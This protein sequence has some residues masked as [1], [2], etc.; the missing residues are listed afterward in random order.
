MNR[1]RTVLL[2]LA[3]IIQAA[4]LQPAKAQGTSTRRNPPHPHV[5]EAVVEGGNKASQEANVTPVMSKQLPDFPGK[6]VV[7]ITVTYPPGSSGQVHRHNA[8]GFIYVLEGSVVMGVNGGEPV[9]LAPGQAFYEGPNDIH[10][11]GRNAS[12]TR[13]AKFLV[14][15]IKDRDAPISVPV[16]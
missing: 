1:Q 3:T 9:T 5:G 11:I 14:I 15:L 10:T 12:K 2:A 4:N 8:H 16:K 7:M 13:P 6:E